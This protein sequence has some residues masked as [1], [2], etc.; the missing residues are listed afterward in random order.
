MYSM[1]IL[2]LQVLAISAGIYLSFDVGRTPSFLYMYIIY[3]YIYIYICIYIYVCIYM[4]VYAVVGIEF[5]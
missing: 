2:H 4:Y 3:I 5:P 1:I